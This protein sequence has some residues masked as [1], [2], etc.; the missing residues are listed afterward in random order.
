MTR[1]PSWCVLVAIAPLPA[2][3]GAGDWPRFRGPTGQG[4]YA[5]GDLPLRWSASDNVAWKTDLPGEGRSSPIVHGDRVFLTTATDQGA[6]CRVLCLDRRTGRLRWDREVFR[7]VPP[8][9]RPENSH[10]TPTPVTDGAGVFAVFGDGSFAALDYS[11]S[12]RWTNRTVKHFSLHGLAASPILYRDLLLMPFD[13]TSPGPDRNL[14]FEKPWDG[15]FVVALDK[16]TG[17]ERWRARRGAARTAHATP[18]V[19]SAQGKDVLISNAGEVVQG[20]DPETG[21]RLWSLPYEGNAPTA[22]V[23]CAEGLVVASTGYGKATLRALELRA[24][25]PPPVRWE[26]PRGVA[27]IASPVCVEGRL[28]QVTDKGIATCLEARTGRVLWEGRIGGTHYASPIHAAGKVYFLSE[29]GRGTVVAAAPDFKVLARND[30][31]EP[32]R[33][34][35]VA[36]RGQLFIRTDKSLY[37]IGKSDGR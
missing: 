10:A 16:H 35:Y 22:S 20:F 13:G 30:L 23:V 33:A 15:C 32:C 6:S 2:A 18:L 21:R 5:D 11:G 27:I 19:V 3:L 24:D 37:C 9:K 12:V 25:G 8:T 28:Y 1:L 34:S 7:Q 14:G 29:E 26:Q 4:L 17:R 36:A 31:G